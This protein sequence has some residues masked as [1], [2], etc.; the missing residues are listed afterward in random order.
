LDGVTR[1]AAAGTLP[2][3]TGVFSGY[4]QICNIVW[5]VKKM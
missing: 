1:D 2:V 5:R 3:F 4:L